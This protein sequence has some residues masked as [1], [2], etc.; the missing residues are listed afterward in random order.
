[1]HKH[2]KNHSCGVTEAGDMDTDKLV[3]IGIA[4]IGGG[5]LFA[6]IAFTIL[7]A[8][9]NPEALAILAP[10]IAPGLAVGAV[11]V[12]SARIRKTADRGFVGACA[13]LAG[14]VFLCT[15]SASAA[16]AD[17]GAVRIINVYILLIFSPVGVPLGVALLA[18][19]LKVFARERLTG[20]CMI[21]PGVGFLP[22]LVYIAALSTLGSEAAAILA[23]V[24]VPTHGGAVVGATMLI[25]G[26][27]TVW[28][29]RRM[30]LG[31][32]PKTA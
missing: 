28:Q 3:R 6:N 32:A 26:L 8:S 23:P 19:G 4:L 21:V 1:M 9:D 11:L 27:V 14:A 30:R 24:E 7:F 13:A 29:A 25:L 18:I 16:A 17:S 2:E 15:Y 22:F 5:I 10:V 31:H 12:A 20:L